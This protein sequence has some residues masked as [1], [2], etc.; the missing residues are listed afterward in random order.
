[1]EEQRQ[2]LEELLERGRENG[3]QGLRI[4]ER[5]ELRKMEPNLS[6]RVAAALYAPTGGI[7]CPFGLTI[8][9]AENACRNG[10]E[11]RFN[12]EV[13]KIEKT[14]QGYRLETSKGVFETRTVVNAAGVYADLFHN[15][16]SG[17]KI[18]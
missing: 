11:F 1:E 15:M 3:V 10:V 8:A 18:H 13:Q 5:E 7:V 12:T 4:L 2:G 6:E 16:A 9:L 14:G 17:T